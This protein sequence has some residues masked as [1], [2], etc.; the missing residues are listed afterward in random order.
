M[1]PKLGGDPERREGPASIAEPDETVDGPDVEV[2]SDVSEEIAEARKIRAT[3]KQKDE[4]SLP[5][6]TWQ[7]EFEE[8]FKCQSNFTD[9]GEFILKSIT[10]LGTPL[11]AFARKW[12]HPVQPPPTTEVAYERKGDLLPIHPTTVKVGENGVT[13]ANFQWVVL[14]LVA[15]NFHYYTGWTGKPICVPMDTK[16][17]ENQRKAIAEIAQVINRNILSADR[18]PTLVEARASLQ[19]KRYDYS[20]NPI[21]HMLDLEADKVIPT[22][23]KVGEAGI[24]CITEFLSGES[25]EVMKDPH[26]WVLPY[27]K[28]PEKAKRSNVRATDAEWEKLVEAAYKRGMMTM[29]E[30]AD[31]PRD[32]QGHLIVNGAGGV[33]KLKEVGGVTKELQRFISILVPTNEATMQLLGEQDSL[34]YIG[35]LTALQLGKNEELY[36]ESEDFQ[37]AFNLFRVPPNWTP[38]FAYSKKVSGAAFG[39]PDLKSVRPALCVI[40]MGWHSAVTLVQ[41]AVRRVVFDLVGV[42]KETSVEKGRELPDSNHLTVV[43]LDN[44]NKIRIVDK[45]RA[46]LEKEG[47]EETATHKKFN[48]VCDKLGLPRNGGK[49]LIKAYSGPMQGG[50]FDGVAG[51]LKL[52]RDKLQNFISI[53]LALL[54]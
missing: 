18:I 35:M 5:L 30:D 43:Y 8:I 33:K 54:T 1:E 52:G 2:M 26:A 24:R 19:S 29:V 12:S 17:S 31:I 34:P 28:M 25:L 36:L 40:P 16:L 9:L 45:L 13:D 32:K 47:Q 14:S 4:A 27:D 46:E 3:M 7:K 20:G 53:S 6:R 41:S 23:P 38:F 48:E 37:S 49:Q 11:G 21:E 39:R 10:W 22:W 15:L 42:P 50:E 51:I 44:Y